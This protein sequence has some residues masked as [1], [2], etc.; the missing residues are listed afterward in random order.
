MSTGHELVTPAVGREA[1]LQW[2]AS[3]MAT[4]FANV[5]NIQSTREQVDLL[6][7]IS[8]SVGLIIDNTL[9]IAVSNRIILT[10]FAAK[11]LSAALSNVL[12]EYEKRY[13][14]VQI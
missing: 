6:F 4:S 9:A 12:Q 2:D 5:V 7:G 1:E 13:G 11:R 10:P 3:L 8:Q 14:A